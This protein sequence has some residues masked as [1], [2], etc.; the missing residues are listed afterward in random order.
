MSSSGTQDGVPAGIPTRDRRPTDPTTSLVGQ[1]WQRVSTLRTCLARRPRRRA[2]HLAELPGGGGAAG[3]IAAVEAEPL[4]VRRF[5]CESDVIARVAGGHLAGDCPL[6]APYLDPARDHRIDVLGQPSCTLLVLDPGGD[7]FG[8]PRELLGGGFAQRRVVGG[9]LGD[10]CQ[11]R[12]P[13]RGAA[14]LG[15]RVSGRERRLIRCGQ[16]QRRSG[17]RG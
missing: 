1:P 11:E 5:A 6:T 8:E 4:R 9:D 14:L 12:R 2:M 13:V 10:G 17:D 16:A 15:L 7:L 3:L